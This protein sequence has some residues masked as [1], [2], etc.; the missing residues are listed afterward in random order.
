M[1]R[2]LKG[3]LTLLLVLVAQITFAQ[4]QKQVTGT[5]SDGQGLPL[6]GVNV[7]V[8]GTNRG[9]QTDF[10]GNFAIMASEGETLVFSYL[11]FETARFLVDE[12]SRLAVTL[13][14][15]AAE[16]EEVVVTAY[17][18]QKRESI[19]GSISELKAEEVA[20]VQ[21][22]NVVQGMTGKVAGVQVINESGQPGSEPTVRFRGIGSINASSAPLYV[23]DGIPFQGNI[24]TINNQDIASVTFLKD[25]S[26]AALYGSRGANGVII[27]TTKK[28]ADRPISVT[29]DVRT[30]INSR[31]VEEYDIM[32]TPGEYYEAMFQAYRNSLIYN[33]ELTPQQ[34][35]NYAA[36]N[37]ITATDEMGLGLGALGL[38]YNLYNVPDGQVIDPSTGRIASNANLLYSENWNDYLFEN[39]MLMQSNVSVSG[40]GENSSVYF[41]LGH[42]KNEGYVINSGFE[43]YTARLSAD[44]NVKDF[45][46]IGGSISYAHTIQKTVGGDGTSAYSNPISWARNIAPIYP[47]FAYDDNGQRMFDA[48]GNP[49][50]DDGTGAF[51]LPVRPYGG[52]QNPVATAQLDI[53]DN[54]NDN[55]FGTAFAKWNIL[56]GLDFTYNLAVDVRNRALT[57]FDT[58]LYGDAKGVNGRATNAFSTAMN[59]TQQQL[60]NYN[61]EIGAHEFSVLVGH[62]S[63][64]YTFKY[65]NLHKINFLLPNVPVLDFAASYQSSRNFV[66]E[67]G[68]EGYFSRLNYDY[69]N[70][71][72]VNASFRRDASSVFHPD[73]RWGNFYGV[74]AAW[75]VSQEDFLS[76]V[77][78]LTEL[79]LKAS[80]GEQGNDAILYP[81]G[82]RNYYAYRDQFSVVP[83]DGELAIQLTYLGNPDLT[84][85]TNANFNAGFEFGL[86]ENRF[87]LNAEYFSREVQDMLFNTP[88]PP[89]SGNPDLPE[90]VGDMIN[91]GVEVTLTADAIRSEDIGLTFHLN[92]THYKNEI[93][94]LPKEDI[95][96]SQFRYNVGGSVYDYY[97]R[98]YAGVNPENGNAQWYMDVLDTN[99]DPT[100]EREITEE[101]AQASFYKFDKSPIPDVYGGFGMDFRFKGFD[102]GLDFAYQIGG[103]GYD[104]V[105]WGLFDASG[106]VGNNLHRDAVTQTWTVDN[107]TAPL[108]RIDTQ[109]TNQFR[110]LSTLYLTDAS[111]LSLQNVNLGYTFGSNVTETVGVNSLRVYALA[112]NVALWSERQG[113]DPRLSLTG[114]SANE[115]SILRTVSVGVNVQF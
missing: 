101:F 33:E 65:M 21:T 66:R 60:L 51:G 63:T 22:S 54:V 36:A 37:L 94:R 34:A 12:R 4:Q 41:S 108:P 31:S 97:L 95:I 9:V 35:S 75:R 115:Y 72:Y 3:I 92:G 85:E 104:S 20:E 88:Q 28:G 6:P 113:Y 80:Y 15:D 112:N 13:T 67:Y 2:K 100:G 48:Q 105:Y 1:K 25:A 69:D 11:G 53:I 16:L 81:D 93:T 30:G 106:D 68:V 44:T 40:G 8:Q 73:N 83:N 71:Y 110:G 99:G 86:F 29:V 82:G 57:S 98:E 18:V 42:E 24:N 50:Y 84:W 111:Y 14:E 52:L 89:S 64:D 78:W 38:N 55:V 17:G 77:T 109:S 47:V 46:N 58:P 103:E 19:T 61:K 56:E 76:D 32:E 43:R 27:I 45:L 96:T 23:V 90:N 5:V 114:V 7:L 62:E 49:L 70:R 91:K 39:Q 79:K 74:G 10:D 87:T 26:A 102:L 107:P 59:F